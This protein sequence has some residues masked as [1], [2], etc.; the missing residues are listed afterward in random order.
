MICISVSFQFCACLALSRLHTRL[1]L[2][3][4]ML[5]T[6]AAAKAAAAATEA[7]V[8][9]HLSQCGACAATADRVPHSWRAYAQPRPA[10]MCA[11]AL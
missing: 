5:L 8:H 7:A 10:A 3:S 6:A 1:G 9:A 4:A 2:T 11:A